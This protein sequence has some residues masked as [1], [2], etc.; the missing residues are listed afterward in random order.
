MGPSGLGSPPSQSS[1]NDPRYYDPLRLPFPLLGSLRF[2]S[3]PNTLPASVGFVF[4]MLVIGSETTQWTPGLLVYRFAS[5]SGCFCHKEV[6]VLSSSQATPV[7]TCPAPTS[8]PVSC[9][10]AV[11][12]TGLESS[13]QIKMSTFTAQYS[14]AYP[15]GPELYHFRRSITRPT[16]SL[17]LASC[18]PS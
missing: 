3:I 13:I 4:S 11:T 15:F 14:A 5:L 10:L 8:P 7:R 1:N 16:R 17:H 18:K 12:R 9:S 6:T 2:R